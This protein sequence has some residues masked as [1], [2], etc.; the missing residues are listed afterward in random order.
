MTAT[1]V[2]SNN[3]D[4][5]LPV[6]IISVSHNSAGVLGRLL[7]SLPRNVEIIVVDNASADRSVTLAEEHGARCIRLESNLGFG[8]A[9]NVG[10]RAATRQF[11]LFVNP[12]AEADT[13]LVTA[14]LAAAARFPKA[15]FNPRIFNGSTASFRRRSRLVDPQ[16]YWRGALPQKDSPIPV[17]TGACI[18]IDRDVFL[19]LGGFDEAIFLYHEDDDLSVRLTKAG[20]HLIYVHDAVLTHQAGNSSGK[21]YRSG[22]IKGKAMARSMAHVAS[23]HRLPFSRMREIM[24]SCL[25]LLSP[26]V[27]FKA[28]R[29]GKYLG[30]LAGFRSRK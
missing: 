24:V 27:L 4:H 9:C 5:D 8:T 22:F 6:S 17:L 14:F 13:D 15:A 28:S 18:F 21:T 23:K 16:H 12:D 11:L 29:R 3:Q 10:A 2:L 19:E 20:H 25:M 30:M 1:P 26:H 7:A